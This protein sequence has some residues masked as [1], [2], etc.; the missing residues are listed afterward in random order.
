[1]LNSCAGSFKGIAYHT[2][3]DYV[4]HSSTPAR[5]SV[6]TH[7]PCFLSELTRNPLQVTAQQWCDALGDANAAYTFSHLTRALQYGH[8]RI[9]ACP[10]PDLLP[11]GIFIV[12]LTGAAPSEGPA[13][14]EVTLCLASAGGRWGRGHG[15]AVLVANLLHFSVGDPPSVDEAD[16][17]LAG[18]PVFD[19]EGHFNTAFVYQA[20]KPRGTEPTYNAAIPGLLP[21]LR[22][23]QVH[24]VAC[25]M[26]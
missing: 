19:G 17:A 21:K 12:N 23:F 24:S 22:T 26:A 3:D 7:C 5:L 15:A 25:N 13:S 4:A 6:A 11:A 8:V 2:K 20:I 16:E 18:V 9:A 14:G 10:P 1:M